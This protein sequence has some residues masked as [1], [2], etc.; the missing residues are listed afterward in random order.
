MSFI[1]W[2]AMWSRGIEP[3]QMFEV[4]EASP[5]LISCLSRRSFAPNPGMRALV[6]GAG[7][8]YD[9]LAL[10]QHGFD[11]VV[12][13]DISPAAI[14][15]AQKFLDSSGSPAAA[16]VKCVAGDF[17]EHAGRYDFIW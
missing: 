14:K 13:L 2:E 1:D 16:K 5:T 12:A 7:R 6:P 11:E 8:S 3:G 10:V 17:F 9:A 15:A 4:G